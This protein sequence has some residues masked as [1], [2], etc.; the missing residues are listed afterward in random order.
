MSVGELLRTNSRRL[1]LD[2]PLHQYKLLTGKH[3]PPVRSDSDCFMSV[4][5]EGESVQQQ[6]LSH[7]P[8][9]SISTSMSSVHKMRYSKYR[10]QFLLLSSITCT[11]ISMSIP[12]ND[13]YPFCFLQIYRLKTRSQCA[14]VALSSLFYA[15]PAWSFAIADTPFYGA[16]H[17]LGSAAFCC[18]IFTCAIADGDLLAHPWSSTAC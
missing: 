12:T 14:A 2:A 1:L 18:V 6:C 4:A 17:R 13:F 16:W 15:I 9:F 3:T 5:K 8:S 10:I 11:P 7:A